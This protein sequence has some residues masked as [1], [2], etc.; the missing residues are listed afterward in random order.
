M[1]FVIGLSILRQIIYNR[2]FQCKSKITSILD[3][4]EMINPKIKKRRAVEE[5]K[6]FGIVIILLF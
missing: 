3:I 2:V 4:A 5:T 6:K 1:S